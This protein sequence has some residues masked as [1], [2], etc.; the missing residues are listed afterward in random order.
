MMGHR[1]W[2]V[3]KALAFFNQT[4]VSEYTDEFV[5]CLNSISL[6]NVC[7]A[8]IAETEAEIEPPKSNFKP[9]PLAPKEDP[10]TGCNRKTYFVCSEPGKPWVKL[11][12]VT[13][14]QIS[15]AR[16]IKKFFTGRLESP[17][18]SM[19]RRWGFVCV[20]FVEMSFTDNYDTTCSEDCEIRQSQRRWDDE[21]E[22]EFI[23]F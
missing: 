17:V 10:R 1:P 3:S 23:F 4:K 19:S 8:E 7:L 13:P 20:Y 6:T 11:P 5:A 14:A 15:V 21:L 16:K 12:I 18:S 22:N 2:C 9:P